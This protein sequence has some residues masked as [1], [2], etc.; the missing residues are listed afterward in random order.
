MNDKWH[1]AE[2]RRGSSVR[3]SRLPENANMDEVRCGLEHG[4]MT[5]TIYRRRRLTKFRQILNISMWLEGG[6]LSSNVMLVDLRDVYKVHVR[7]SFQCVGLHAPSW[8]A[9]DQSLT[10]CSV[11]VNISFYLCYEIMQVKSL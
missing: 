5:V 10:L 4:V 8:S 6:L 7:R 1:R 2:R 9:L 3:R 11:D